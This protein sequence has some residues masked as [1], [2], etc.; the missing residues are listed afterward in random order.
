VLFITDEKTH[1]LAELTLTEGGRVE[2]PLT[3]K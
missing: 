3:L 1:I 2:V